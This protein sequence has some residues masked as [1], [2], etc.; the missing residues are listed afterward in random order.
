MIV[1]S[2]FWVGIQVSLKIKGA[3][4]LPVE[5]TIHAALRLYEPTHN[6][7]RFLDDAPVARYLKGVVH[8][9]CPVE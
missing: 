4:V 6:V 5:Q 7:S 3:L 8:I 1:F 2:I 9:I